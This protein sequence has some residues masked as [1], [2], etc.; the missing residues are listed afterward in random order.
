MPDMNIFGTADWL[1]VSGLGQGSHLAI[2]QEIAYVHS[3]GPSSE[4]H[5]LVNIFIVL[6]LHACHECSATEAQGEAR[7]NKQNLGMSPEY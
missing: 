4:I 5:S 7:H 2:Q 6:L 3:L 1:S